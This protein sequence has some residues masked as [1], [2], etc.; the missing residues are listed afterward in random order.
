MIIAKKDAK[1][2]KSKSIGVATVGWFAFA[3]DTASTSHT[4]AEN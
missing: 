1:S 2:T 3:F 4:A